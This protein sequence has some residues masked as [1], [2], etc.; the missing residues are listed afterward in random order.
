MEACHRAYCDA[1]GCRKPSLLAVSSWPGWWAAHCFARGEPAVRRVRRRAQGSGRTKVAIGKRLRILAV[2][3]L[4]IE[5]PLL[6]LSQQRYELVRSIERVAASKTKSVSLVTVQHGV[7]RRRLGEILK[8]GEGWDVIHFSGHG[9]TTRLLLE[10]ASGQPDPVSTDE[11][12]Q[13]LLFARGRL[14]L[15]VLSSCESGAAAGN[16]AIRVCE[17]TA[18]D[19]TSRSL[20]DSKPLAALAVEAAGQ[21]DCAV[22]GMRYRVSDDF[23]IALTHHLYDNLIDKRNP[24]PRAMQLALPEALE[25]WPEPG[26]P[27][28]SVATPALFGRRGADLLLE[29]PAA[30][31]SFA[32]GSLKMSYFDREPQLFVGRVEP[33]ATASRALA[34]NDHFSGILFH[35]ADP[36]G[37]TACAV[38]LAYLH[39]DQFSRL[40]W[41]Q[42]PTDRKRIEGSLVELAESLETQ[43][44]Q[45]GPAMKRAAR[46]R[47]K[48]ERF[49]PKL[50][51]LMEENGIL[52]FIDGIEGLLTTEGNWRDDRWRLVVNALLD[53]NRVSRLVLTSQRLPT[54]LHDRLCVIPVLPLS[55]EEALLLARQ[56]PRFGDVL[57]GRTD[58]SIEYAA[59]LIADT[60]AASAGMPG[61]IH[62]ADNLLTSPSVLDELPAK[63]AELASAAGN[64]D[65]NIDRREEYLQLV[66]VWTRGIRRSRASAPRAPAGPATSA[67]SVSG[68]IDSEPTVQAPAA[69]SPI[70]GNKAVVNI[71]LKVTPKNEVR[72]SRR[73]HR[74]ISGSEDSQIPDS[75]A[76]GATTSNEAGGEPNMP[77]LSVLPGATKYHSDLSQLLH[78]INSLDD[79]PEFPRHL[80][81]ESI[82]RW[83]FLTRAW[84]VKAERILNDASAIA[85]AR[86]SRSYPSARLAQ[87]TADARAG[88][89]WIR[90]LMA[91]DGNSDDS[92]QFLRHC[93]ETVAAISE[94]A[95]FA[96]GS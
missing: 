19:E 64:H 95:A 55:P 76:L 49:L 14:K 6:L 73:H 27:P 12:L 18:E 70:P 2:F 50:T 33:M 62:E 35:A 44:E 37:K 59:P 11:L 21:L 51:E 13:M 68:H 63:I 23:S 16:E 56:L 46:S 48:L 74:S 77:E 54:V 89:A 52:V 28:L 84:L 53:D 17:S 65:G 79:I 38:E 85:A 24:L 10:G 61:F 43:L 22:L 25:H 88:L 45:F 9:L 60:L 87:A 69:N 78:K 41:Y 5:E 20:E 66:R 67:P 81:G 15:L 58:L 8:Q 72:L 86:E 71:E 36:T 4:P 42:A 39:K 75:K 80:T 93:E 29:P 32:P 1:I 34:R 83:Q 82:F 96:A 57:R 31:L 40:V 26:N 91:R 92:S 90:Q 47:K 30:K 7:T 94:I 3:S